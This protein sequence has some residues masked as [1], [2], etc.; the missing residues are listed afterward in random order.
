MTTEEKPPLTEDEE[1]ALLFP[2]PVELMVGKITIRIEP[3]D[4]ATCSRFAQKA[5]PILKQVLGPLA[6]GADINVMIPTLVL[7]AAEFP[8]EWIAALAI[9]AK[10]SPFFIGRLP[11]SFAPLLVQTIFKVNIDFFAQSV[12]DLASGALAMRQEKAGDGAGLTH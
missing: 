9:A 6:I 3:M 2:E 4:L 8:D 5:R 1:L 7:A 11:P 10:K 12:G